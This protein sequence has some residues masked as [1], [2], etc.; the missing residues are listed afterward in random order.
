MRPTLLSLFQSPLLTTDA[1]VQEKCKI[2]FKDSDHGGH[3]GCP[4]ERNLANFDLQVNLML[5]TKFRVNGLFGSREE[6]QNRFSK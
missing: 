6:P 3:L 5:S 2:D 1:R 4:I